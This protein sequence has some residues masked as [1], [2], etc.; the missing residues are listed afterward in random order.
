M[1]APGDPA[2]A[3]D[4]ARRAASVSH[5]GE[6]IYAA[7]VIAA[8][9]ALAFVERDITALLD[10][11]VAFIPGDSTICR[12]IDD[13]CEWRDQTDDWRQAYRKLAAGYGYDRYGGGCHVVPN[14]GVVILSLLWGEGDFQKTMMI[15]NTC[16]WDT[17]CNSGNAGCIMGIRGG[18]DGIDAGPDWRGPVADRLLLPTADGGRCITDAAREAVAIANVGRALAGEEAVAPKE[19]ARFHFEL[20]GSVQG[21]RGD[22]TPPCRG[23]VSLA[24]VAGHSARGR[25]ALAVRFARLAPGRTAR[26]TTPTFA[27]PEQLRMGGHGLAACPT[28]YPGQTVEAELEADAGNAAPMAARLML[29]RYAEGDELVRLAGEAVELAP[30]QRRRL[31]WTVPATGGYPIAEVGVELPGEPPGAG[32]DGAVYLD[33]LTWGGA[34]NVAF[35]TL[36]GSDLSWRQAWLDAA[37]QRIFG[38]AIRVTSNGGPAMLIQGTRDWRDYRVSAS[39][40][41]HMADEAG[42]AARVQGLRRYYALLLARGGLLRLVKMLNT[43]QVLAERDIGWEF[44]ETLLLELEVV[45]AKLRGRLGGKTVLRARDPHPLDGGAIAL[46]TRLGR[47]DFDAVRVRP[48]D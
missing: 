10:A 16:G 18:L 44:D 29:S 4:L 5:D 30:G 24:N 37:D 46:A 43:P 48:V 19:G 33:Y 35:P 31:R 14:H 17:D 21:F 6:A 32:A 2:L 42:I 1:I 47:A 36:G 23:V 39:V 38:E 27:T 41:P 3:A 22:E 28:L 25:R 13:L 45:G 15:V 40:R 34:P 12:V 8:V 7:Q 9:E 11:A 26:A 20:P